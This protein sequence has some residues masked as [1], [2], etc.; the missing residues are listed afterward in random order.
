[1]SLKNNSAPLTIRQKA[2]HSTLP[3][4][5]PKDYD[6][7]CPAIWK[8]VHMNTRGNI[9][10]CCEWTSMTPTLETELPQL[11]S[12]G[13]EG[14]DVLQEARE[15]I[16]N[17]K[18]PKGCLTCKTNESKGIKSHRQ[19]LIGVLGTV[20][21]NYVKDNLVDSGSIE[22]LD[23]RLGNTCNFMC[24]FCNPNNSH[25]IGKEWIADKSGPS[26]K[27]I[28]KQFL[29]RE[30]VKKTLSKTI[31]D[32]PTKEEFVESIHRYRN[33]KIVKLGGG[34]PFFQKK[35]TFRIIEKIP[36]KEKVKLRILT[37]CSVYDEEILQITN[38]FREVSLALS[39]D[40]TGRTLEISRWKSNWK[41]IQ[42]NVRKLKKW[43]E[44][45][46]SNLKLSLIPAMSVYT[47]L[48]LPNLL[49]FATEQ[50][51]PTNVGFV[52]DPES[53]MI[54][55]IREKYLIKLKEKIQKRVAQG[56]IRKDLID[57]DN[58]YSQ[59]DYAILNNGIEKN[60]IKTFWYYQKY[61]E[62]NRKYKLEK[63]LPELF[64]KI[65]KI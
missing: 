28:A 64:N 58:I 32:H 52:Q 8:Q 53:Q 16:I 38:N 33:L 22:Y 59:L 5:L 17:G 19:D 31:S 42:E 6:L 63:E 11:S 45:C 39:I 2:K 41:S 27:N 30:D 15:T 46:N 14:T 24:N 61:F 55:L 20:N 44:Y 23:I 57:L 7:Y 10:P 35:Q 56:K 51:I 21:K 13:P 1:M 34:E 4:N 36:Y 18:I 49:E 29:F 12:Y 26:P 62:R 37:N 40:A 25:L 47:I 65:K 3:D 54:N 60:T 50:E 43:R 9:F 48:D